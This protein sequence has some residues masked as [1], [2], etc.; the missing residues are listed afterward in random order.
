[1]PAIFCDMPHQMGGVPGHFFGPSSE[2]GGYPVQFMGNLIAAVAGTPPPGF[3][4]RRRNGRLPAADFQWE[5]QKPR[6]TRLNRRNGV[7]NGGLPAICDECFGWSSIGAVTR[8]DS[9]GGAGLPVADRKL[10]R[11]E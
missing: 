5:S 2:N 8:V 10:R 9:P 6:G 11:S 4:S 7:K 3:E 1:V